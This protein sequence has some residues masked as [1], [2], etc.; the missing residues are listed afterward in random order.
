MCLESDF[1]DCEIIATLANSLPTNLQMILKQNHPS[2]L[3][4][5]FQLSGYKIMLVVLTH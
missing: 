4:P 1:P 5:Y 2:K 3:I